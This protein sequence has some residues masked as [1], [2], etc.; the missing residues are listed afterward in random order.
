MVTGLYWGDRGHCPKCG[1]FCGSIVGFASEE[2]LHRVVG[3]CSVHGSVDLSGQAWSHDE[4][5]SEVVERRE[6]DCEKNVG[7]AS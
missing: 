1:R 2:K 3:K 6:D 4:F 5:Y 7:A